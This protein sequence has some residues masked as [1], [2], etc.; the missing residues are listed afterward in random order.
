MTEMA[1]LLRDLDTY[2]EEFADFVEASPSSFHA[3]QVLAEALDG[4]GFVELD[5]TAGWPALVPAACGF[6]RRD[7]ALIAW[8]AGAEITATS[9][10]RLIGCHTDSPGFVLKPQPDFETEGWAQLG[11]EVYG[12]PLLNSWLDRDLALA[13]R[14]VTRGGSAHL[15]RTGAVARIPQLAIHLDR[16]VGQGLKLD[17]QRH[18]Q[19]ILGVAGGGASALELLAEAAGVGASEI[20][21]LDVRLADTQSPARIGASRELLA[22]PRLDNLS[23]VFAGF[24]ALLGSEPARDPSRCWPRSTTRSSVPNPVPVRRGRSSR[25]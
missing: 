12:G 3:V 15:A 9:P 17:R 24:T 10:L 4:A 21:G 25:R 7:G 1:D 14:I 20:V 22:S 11:V 16:E 23:S 2:I 6:V 13:G 19:P 8:R 18:T 5:E